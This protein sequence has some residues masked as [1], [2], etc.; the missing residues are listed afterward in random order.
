MR[1]GLAALAGWALLGIALPVA[2]C[3]QEAAGE[4]ATTREAPRESGAALSSSEVPA[5]LRECHQCHPRVVETF[6]RHAMA[7]SLGTLPVAPQGELP[8]P[9]TGAR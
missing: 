1:A 4:G 5:A 3:G 9:R 6:M 8:C 2:G 7:D